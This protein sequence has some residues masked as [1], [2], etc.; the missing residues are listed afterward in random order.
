MES[1]TVAS[2]RLSRPAAAPFSVHVDISKLIV[3]RR[4][5]YRANW[6]CHF[7]RLL[8]EI[9]LLNVPRRLL[10]SRGFLSCI[11]A[12]SCDNRNL[13]TKRRMRRIE[14]RKIE[15]RK[16]WFQ[17]LRLLNWYWYKVEI[18]IFERNREK[19]FCFDAAEILKNI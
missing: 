14:M 10:Y 8:G 6:R 1:L 3:T 7:D 5:T 2:G 16:G 18:Y 19:Q 13:G 12:A 4:R 9:A 17:I 15:I 11:I